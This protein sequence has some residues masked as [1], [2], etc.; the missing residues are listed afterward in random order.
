MMLSTCATSSSVRLSEAPSG[1]RM[2]AKKAPWS[3]AGRK[4][5]GVILKSPNEA[6][7]TTATADQAE[8]RDPHQ[9]AHDGDV[10]VAHPVDAAST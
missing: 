6:A 10:A 1:R 8:D 2:A 9:P 4:P 5:C 7:S 3:S